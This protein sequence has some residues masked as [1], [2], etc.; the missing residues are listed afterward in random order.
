MLEGRCAI[1]GPLITLRRERRFYMS[2]TIDE[3]KHPTREARAGRIV[4]DMKSSQEYVT[5]G[6]VIAVKGSLVKVCQLKQEFYDELDDPVSFIQSLR[7]S[8]IKADI[9]TFLGKFPEST[10]QHDYSHEWDN[11]AAI[12]ITTFEQWHQV[13]LPRSTRRA[14]RKAREEGVSVRKVDFD[15]DLVRR[16]SEIFDESPVR[17]GRPFWHYKKDFASVKEML[18]RDAAFS[19]Y[20]CAFVGDEMVGFVKLI[21]KR[22]FARTGLIM[23]KLAHRKKYPTNLLIA[24]AVEMCAAEGI[25]YLVY[26]QLDYGKAGSK[27][28]AD[29]KVHNG[30]QRILLPR[31]FVPLNTRGRVLMSL[32]LHHGALALMPRWLVQGVLQLRNRWYLALSVRDEFIEPIRRF[33]SFH[34]LRIGK[35]PAR[36]RQADGDD[37]FSIVESE[38][39]TRT[40]RCRRTGTAGRN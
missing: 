29:F 34:R 16:I 18:L 11:V 4:L 17:Q 14:L 19:R 35:T 22:N 40:R 31:Y 39:Q 15:D 25:R 2:Q 10:L 21:C 20:L 37:S 1:I 26:G 5:N 12:P 24:T 28:L 36:E 30:F 7:N 23:S 38:R 9:L 32:G 33:A 8:G 3:T 27:T 13:D 6:H